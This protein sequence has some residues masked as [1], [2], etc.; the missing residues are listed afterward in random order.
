MNII[1]PMA[2][3]GS[4]LRPHTLTTP[5]PLVPVAGKPIV[6]WLVED[7]IALSPEK[8]DTIGFVIGDFGAEVEQNL[9]AIAE[10][11]GAKGQIFYQKEALGTAHAIDCASEIL[12]G[13]TIVAFADTLFKTNFKINTQDEGVIFVQK[14]DDPSAFGVVKLSN[15]GIIT[16]FVEKPN[17]F[18]SDLAIIGI[19]YFRDGDR[20]NAAIKDLIRN[21]IKYKGEFQLTDVMETLRKEGTQYRPGEVDEWLDCGNKDATVNTNQRM[22]DIKLPQG[23]QA[24]SVKIENA[25]I[26]PPCFIGENVLLKNV[27]IGPYVSIGDDS[28][29]LNSVISNTIIQKNNHIQGVIVTN[30][31]IGNSVEYIGRVKDLSIGDYTKIQE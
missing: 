20:L 29:I 21:D 14:V 8:I 16:D 26:I 7:L 31:M 15:D 1:I 22:L 17:V 2:G 13:P 19:Y 23:Q 3:R 30:S 25:T 11:L 28:T 6:E 12:T 9:I 24:E 10:R 4:R 18:V 27:V 5:K